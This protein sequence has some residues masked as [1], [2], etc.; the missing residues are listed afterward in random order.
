MIAV[1]AANFTDTAKVELILMR[2][3]TSAN[4]LYRQSIA[5]SDPSEI[6]FDDTIKKLTEL[7][8]KKVSVLRTR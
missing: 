6:S 5:P 8:K 4:A 2:L 7:F 3:E 1:G